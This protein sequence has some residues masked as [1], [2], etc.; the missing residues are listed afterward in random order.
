MCKLCNNVMPSW[1][2]FGKTSNMSIKRINKVKE[3]NKIVENYTGMHPCRSMIRAIGTFEA[4]GSEE[5]DRFII[6]KLYLNYSKNIKKPKLLRKKTNKRLETYKRKENNKKYY[7]NNIDIKTVSRNIVKKENKNTGNI[8]YI[9][10]L[11]HQSS[12]GFKTL[13]EAISFRDSTLQIL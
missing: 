12:K 9:T 6:N 2:D 11:L 13:E 10:K 7:K 3:Y 4:H 8:I 1:Y 5:I